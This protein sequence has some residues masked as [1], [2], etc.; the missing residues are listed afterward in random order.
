MPSPTEARLNTQQQ[1]Y[2]GHI[3]ALSVDLAGERTRT[4]QLLSQLSS[5]EV[6][7]HGDLTSVQT[8]Y[9]REKGRADL[10]ESQL[11]VH[12]AL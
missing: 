3:E 7:S 10:L 12:S 6:G 4:E 11:K 8:A 1:E 5:A 2:E 9:R